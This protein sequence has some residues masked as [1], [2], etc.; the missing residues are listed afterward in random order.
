MA[1]GALYQAHTAFRATRMLRSLE[2]GQSSLDIHSQW[3]EPDIRSYVDNRTQVWSYAVR[4]NTN[5]ITAELLYTAPKEGDAGRFLDLKFV[6]GKLSSWAEAEHAMPSKEGSGFSY[7][8][9]GVP[10]GNAVHY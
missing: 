8:I 2:A 4:P 1:C 10:M 9:G 6:D 5:D 3:G 7:G